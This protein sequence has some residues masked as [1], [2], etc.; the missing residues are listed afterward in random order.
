[1]ANMSYCRFRNTEL[2]VRECIEAL[3]CGNTISEDEAVAARKMF[4]RVLDFCE[5]IGIINGWNRTRLED[6]LDEY[7][8]EE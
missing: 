3:E 2:D 6:M 5:R 8:E 1:M 7:K 4:V